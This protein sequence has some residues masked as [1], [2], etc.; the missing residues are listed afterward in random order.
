MKPLVLFFAPL[1]LMAFGC[2]GLTIGRQEG[3]ISG[4]IV[5]I[6][7]DPVR[8]ADVEI[9]TRST[10]SNSSGAYVMT[11]VR[12]GAWSLKASIVKGGVTYSG[13]TVAQIFEGD[14]TR[15]INL[16][17]VRVNQQA[18]MHGVVKDRFGNVLQGAKVYAFLLNPS[19]FTLS[20]VVDVTNGLGEYDLKSLAAGY[21]YVVRAG[22]QGYNSD[23]DS[24]SLSAG[25]NRRFDFVL[26]DPD[27][28]QLP[29]PQNL[30]A[31]AWTSPDE[32]GRNAQQAR[33]IEAIKQIIDPRRKE[34]KAGGQLRTTTNG[35]NVEV[36][37][38][39]D[40]PTTNLSSYLGY[41]IYRA[42]SA[43][44][45]SDPVDFMN[46]PE[47]A[48]YGDIDDFLRED[49]NYYYEITALNVNY[50]TTAN[51]ESDF[52]NRYG[53]R[54]LDEMHANPVTQAPLTFR[55]DAVQDADGYRVFLFDEYPD[56]GVSAIWFN[57]TLA[58]GTSVAYSGSA[59]VS[60]RQYYYVVLGLANS[61]DSRTISRV[62][63]FIAN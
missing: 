51:S 3:E 4:N 59:L 48:F 12:E 5:D 32:V 7:G 30:V 46:D 26:D 24:V 6:N 34:K 19:G 22:G 61:D 13:Q 25:E 39:W 40:S 49:T 57:S 16:A 41:G 33:A 21:T 31:V 14:R 17:L 60:G 38:Y 2:G 10:T 37:L 28:P 45:F 43:G 58:T 8:G 63:S 23:R 29:A 35:Y 53:V 44:G 20:S 15:N 27:D 9:D 42:L 36:D 47:A 11:R 56:L 50:P 18:S 62:E 52:S 55:W 54:T 1:A